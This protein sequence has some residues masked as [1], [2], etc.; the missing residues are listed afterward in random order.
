MKTFF[1]TRNY[2]IILLVFS[3]TFAIFSTSVSALGISPSRLILD[4]KPNMKGEVDF[5]II[6]NEEKNIP[7][8]TYV[9]GDLKE[10]V[11]IETGRIILS[12]SERYQCFVYNYA[13]PAELEPGHHDTRVGAVEAYAGVVPAGGGTTIAA[14]IAVEHQLW[15]EVPYPGKYL[16]ATIEIPSINV[17]QAAPIKVYVT[18]LGSENVIARVSIEIFDFN[19]KSLAVLNAGEGFV[20]IGKVVEFS[21]LWSGSDEI[22]DYRA[23]A[24]IAYAD[25]EQEYTKDFR[26]GDF[27]IQIKGLTETTIVKKGIQPLSVELQSYWNDDIKNVYANMKVK[28]ND[29]A[30]VDLSTE[31]VDFAPWAGKT[32]TTYLDTT[33]LELGD[34]K[35][36]VTVYYESETEI[37]VFDIK[38]ISEEEAEKRTALSLLVISVVISILI[39]LFA[40][41]ASSRYLKKTKKRRKR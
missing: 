40:A 41:I 29:T 10:Y 33:K 2:I 6:N 13:F 17:N 26:V 36:V 20:E 23:V 22:G 32:L 25:K 14:R 16:S 7:V 11:T 3:I 34:Y 38:L 18:N 1:K 30:L 31:T 9:K 27:L 35:L 21:A 15:V 39:V 37:G 24:T 8:D 4:F 28:R 12:S 19:N 5:C